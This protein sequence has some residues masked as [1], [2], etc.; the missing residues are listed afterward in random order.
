MLVCVWNPCLIQS[1]FQ[2][3]IISAVVSVCLHWRLWRFWSFGPCFM[4]CPL[5]IFLPLLSLLINYKSAPHFA[6]S[7]SLS[8]S[9]F[10]IATHCGGLLIR[11]PPIGK[12]N[13][14]ALHINSKEFDLGVVIEDKEFF[15]LR[16]FGHE[17]RDFS[18]NWV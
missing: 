17:K 5:G 10:S 12:R 7:F 15:L 14:L 9:L 6:L 1:Q 16:L 8:L 2:C 4:R 13:L 3:F 11:S 18:R